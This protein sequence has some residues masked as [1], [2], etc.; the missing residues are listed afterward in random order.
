MISISYDDDITKVKSALENIVKQ[1][2]FVL[3]KPEPVIT[4]NE[5]T[6]SSIN[7]LIR[8]TVQPFGR[9]RMPSFQ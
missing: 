9:G 4:I 8:N 5:Y 7:F 3:Q 2:R 1:S 6:G